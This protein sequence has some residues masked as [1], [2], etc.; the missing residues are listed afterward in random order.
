MAR[1]HV[2]PD[3]VEGVAF[4]DEP[5]VKKGRGETLIYARIYSRRK[6]S[7]CR[8]VLNGRGRARVITAMEM[9]TKIRRLY[10]RRGN[11]RCTISISAQRKGAW[12]SRPLLFVIT[13]INA[14]RCC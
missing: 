6:M 4:D 13:P 10:R 5:W 9:D 14:F 3:E 11:V 1:H 2:S 7:L 8:L 12:L